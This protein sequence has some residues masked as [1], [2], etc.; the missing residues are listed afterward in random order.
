ML[1]LKSSIFLSQSVLVFKNSSRKLG[2]SY[3][4]GKVISSSCSR[5]TSVDK[6]APPALPPG[7]SSRLTLPQSSSSH[8][9]PV[10]L[11]LAEH[12]LTVSQARQAV[13]SPIYAMVPTTPFTHDGFL[14]SHST[15]LLAIQMKCK[16]PELAEAFLETVLVSLHVIPSVINSFKGMNPSHSSLYHQ[17]QEP[18]GVW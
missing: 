14:L 1:S 6:E 18:S 13:P 9:G 10:Y 11:A 4:T 8:S 2:L 15:W 5:E 3:V 7:G 17:H 12:V 16:T